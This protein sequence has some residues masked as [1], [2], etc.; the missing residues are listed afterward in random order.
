MALG[1]LTVEARNEWRR[2]W[3]VAV[4][5]SVGVASSTI[6]SYSVGLFIEPL[7]A[8]FGW[9]R[10][11]I[12]AGPAIPAITCIVLTPFVGAIVDQFGPRWIA[13]GGLAAVLMLTVTLGLIGPGISSWLAI[14]VLFA[15]LAPLVLPNIWATAVAGAFSSGRGL[16]LGLTLAGSGFSSIVTPV[17]SFWLIAEFGWR[18]AFSGLAI[19]WGMIALP[20]GLLWFRSSGA[21]RSHS[22]NIGNFRWHGLRQSGILTNRFLVLALG[23]FLFGLVV[24]SLVINLVPVLTW[25]GLAR[26]EAAGIASLLGFSAIAGRML[27]GYLLDHIEARYLAVA[28]CALPTATCAL[29]I[30]AHG[31]LAVTIL[32]VVML[33]FALGAE[34]DI[35]AYMASRYFSINHFGLLFGTLAGVIA[36]AGAGGPLWVNALYDATGSYL[37]ALQMALPLCPFAAVL[38]FL[39]GPYPDAL[40]SVSFQPEIQP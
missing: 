23:A 32:A 27:V 24:P 21:R 35:V 8:E 26:S 25:G 33:G 38:F 3:P 5:A 39:L 28:I 11:A 4:A 9:S 12:S 14:W 22:V 37:T 34:Y 40:S 29:L 30:G 10:A 15:F 20:I 13:L 18:L 7:Q 2:H 36:F 1:M 6:H 31:S 17:L 19:V 16:A